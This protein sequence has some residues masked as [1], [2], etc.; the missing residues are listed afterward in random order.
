MYL[1]E[2]YDNEQAGIVVQGLRPYGRSSN[3]NDV[4]I[5]DL[6]NTQDV[7][8]MPVVGEPV[9]DYSDRGSAHNE[10]AAT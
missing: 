5:E 8:N 2:Q 7:N 6:T 9:I 3:A 10:G 1:Q 4:Q